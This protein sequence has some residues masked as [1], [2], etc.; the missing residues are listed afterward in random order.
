MHGTSNLA[1]RFSLEQ[2]RASPLDDACLTKRI[3]SFAMARI[4][5]WTCC[6]TQGDDDDSPKYV[7]NYAMVYDIGDRMVAHRRTRSVLGSA[8]CQRQNTIGL[9]RQLWGGHQYFVVLH[10]S[11]CR[12]LPIQCGRFVRPLSRA[13]SAAG[14]SGQSI[15]LEGKSATA[16]RLWR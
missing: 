1:S 16:G 13:A 15:C 10:R 6:R 14:Q 3:D 8:Y 12:R 4:L 9:P 11:G 7:S 2:L 5:S